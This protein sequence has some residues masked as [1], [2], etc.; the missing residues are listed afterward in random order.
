MVSSQLEVAVTAAALKPKF[1]GVSHQYAFFVSIIT[2]VVLV[3]LASGTRATTAAIIYAVAVSALFGTSALYHRVNWSTQAARRWMRRL[4]HTMIFVLIAGTFTPV[5]LLVLQ[6]T[7]GT[8]LLAVVW[9]GALLGV[10][11]KFVWIDAPKWLIA[12]LYVALGWVA[13]IAFPE[14]LDRA[15]WTA[16][17]LLLGGGLLYS[18]GAVVYATKK[19]DPVPSVFGYHEV[20]HVLVIGAAALHYA[21]ISLFVLPFA[22]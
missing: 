3:L 12:V 10:V 16:F 4:D 13:V 2:G 17:G 11:F 8:V 21:C 19:P 7:I 9:G 14:L 5:C 15:G 6:G 22:A 20:F 18:I 1:R